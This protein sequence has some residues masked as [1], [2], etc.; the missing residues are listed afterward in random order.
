VKPIFHSAL[1]SF[2]ETIR[3][4]AHTAK[5]IRTARAEMNGLSRS[6]SPNQTSNAA[7]TQRAEDTNIH[8]PSYIGVHVRRGDLHATS[9]A[10]HKGYVP[11]I[12]YAQAALATWSRLF[13]SSSPST[14]YI[15]SDSPSAERELSDA[16]PS[17]TSV[18]SLSRSANPELRTLASPKE[19][20]QSEFAGLGE[21]E[22]INATRGMIVDFAMVS[23]MWAWPDDVIPDA[24]VCTI[25][26]VMWAVRQ[27][28]VADLVD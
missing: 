26:C 1:V 2:N 7:S 28:W 16:L 21:E 27:L 4:N 14:I 25:G 12:N 9:W 6:I 15:A 22:R 18:L 20:V 23:G 3:P 8:L 24:T 19:Y 13:P 17:N 5:L 10:F 11:I